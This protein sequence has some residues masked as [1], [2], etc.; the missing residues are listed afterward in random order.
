[1]EALAVTPLNTRNHSQQLADRNGAEEGGIGQCAVDPD[2]GTQSVE[3]LREVLAGLVDETQAL[4]RQP[5]Q[6]DVL[7]HPGELLQDPQALANGFVQ[8][9][10][11]GDGRSMPLCTAKPCG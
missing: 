6:W 2:D 8:Q 5:G 9:V 3:R 1:M 4:E 10:D 11:Y 7:S